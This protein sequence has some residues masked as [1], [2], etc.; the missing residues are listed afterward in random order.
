MLIAMYKCIDISD[1][2]SLSLSL[3]ILYIS[4]SVVMYARVIALWLCIYC[5]NGHSVHG[6][7]WSDNMFMKALKY[8]FPSNYSTSLQQTLLEGNEINFSPLPTL[9]AYFNDENPRIHMDGYVAMR[10]FDPQIRK[11]KPSLPEWKNLTHFPLLNFLNYPPT[12][13]NLNGID[14]KVSFMSVLHW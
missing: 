5:F 2:P 6:Y 10:W 4:L 13:P 1:G 12:F 9:T 14:P 8:S 11:W 3:S 7:S